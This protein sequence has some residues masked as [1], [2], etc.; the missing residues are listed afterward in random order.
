MKFMSFLKARDGD[1]DGLREWFF[2]THVPDVLDA[3]PDL[4]RWEVRLRVAPPPGI[5]DFMKSGP[6]TEDL[7]VFDLLAESW[8][9]SRAA[10]VDRFAG[11]PEIAAD[12]AANTARFADYRVVE[13]QAWDHR[14]GVCPTAFHNIGLVRWREGVADGELRLH[15]EEHEWNA[16]RVH[17]GA[18]AYRRDWIEEP[19][20]PDAPTIHGVADLSFLTAED[21]AKRHFS[22]ARGTEEIANDLADFVDSFQS[23]VFGEHV[24]VVGSG[25]R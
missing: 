18:V 3:V 7:P 16:R 14:G 19:L 5:P 25:G 8:F 2:E 4:R 23:L 22:S 15:W 11:R 6:D 10:F 21:L 9:D 13:H 20:G 12:L 17:Y 1:L 24:Y